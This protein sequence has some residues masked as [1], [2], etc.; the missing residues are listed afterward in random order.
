MHEGGG[1]IVDFWEIPAV[2]TRY[3]TLNQSVVA[4]AG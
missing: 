3:G 4:Y 1:L 2:R